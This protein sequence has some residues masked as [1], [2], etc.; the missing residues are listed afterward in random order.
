MTVH[1]AP[2][3]DGDDDSILDSLFD[4]IGDTVSDVVG[5]AADV[6][7]DIGSRAGTALSLTSYPK[8]SASLSSIP[9]PPTRS[10][11]LDNPG[12]GID[13]A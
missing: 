10:D 7:E 12:F 3:D 9:A 5:G 6:L 4:T 2:P 8:C 13:P 1:R 11:W